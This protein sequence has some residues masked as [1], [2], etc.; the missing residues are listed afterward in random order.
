MHK[1][2]P[3]VVP[4]VAMPLLL[5]GCT[6]FQTPL[7]WFQ[8]SLGWNRATPSNERKSLVIP[9]ARSSESHLAEAE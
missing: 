2:L 4:I 9:P 1:R 3:L 5:A 7:D 6:G 8:S